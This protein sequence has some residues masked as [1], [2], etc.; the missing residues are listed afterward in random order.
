MLQIVT[1]NIGGARKL[2]QS[3]HNPHKLGQDAAATL[4]Q[5]I[6]PAQPAFIGL[7]ETGWIT[8][9]SGETHTAHTAVAAA[10][11]EG[12]RARFAPEIVST[13]HGH[14]RLWGRDA[15]TGMQSAAEG[16]GFVTNLPSTP[17]DWDTHPSAAET[18]TSTFIGRPTLYSTGNRD[19]QPRNLVVASVA[20]PEYGPLYIL[21]THFGTLTGEDRHNP[22]H[23]R[24][25]F[26][27][28]SR[29]RQARQVLSVVDE[30]RA[31]ERA[32]ERPSRPVIL[33]GDFNAVPGSR[34]LDA[35]EATFTRLTPQTPPADAW[36]H[37]GHR[38]LIDHIFVDDPAETLP[39]ARCFIQTNL[40]F[41]DLSDH[42]PVIAVF[43]PE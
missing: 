4:R 2:R 6:D 34:S 37:T 11:G 32:H 36:T 28:A 12:Y 5:H 26:G 30:L 38:L 23:P 13:Q 31:A 41:D 22:D 17:W 29:A 14:N 10:L 15:Y 21:N 19:T 9:Q 16:N 25:R 33:V 1:M 8:W 20:H 3:P 18:W 7:Q 24:S 43:T 35:L 40:P 42:R 27:E 39:D